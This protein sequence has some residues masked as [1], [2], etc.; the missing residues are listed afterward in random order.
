LT[1]HQEPPA[2]V[3]EVKQ[4]EAKEKSWDYKPDLRN[5]PGTTPTHT[6]THAA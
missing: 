4:K 5:S 3:K 1:Y 2:A 6:P